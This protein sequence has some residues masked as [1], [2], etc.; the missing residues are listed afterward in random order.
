M[1]Y[2]VWRIHVGW[3]IWLVKPCDLVFLRWFSHDIGGNTCEKLA[4]NSYP[5][6]NQSQVCFQIFDVLGL[7]EWG[8]A[9]FLAI[10]QQLEFEVPVALASPRLPLHMVKISTHIFKH[11]LPQSFCVKCCWAAAMEKF[12]SVQNL[13]FPQLRV[14][15][16]P[17]SKRWTDCTICSHSPKFW[18]QIQRWRLRTAQQ[19][20]TRRRLDFFVAQ[21]AISSRFWSSIK[22]QFL[23][24]LCFPNPAETWWRLRGVLGDTQRRLWRR[25]G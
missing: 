1:K 11:K 7:D 22:M 5:C 9:S 13:L 19:L 8:T 16:L 18:G 25:C 14:F 12:S 24:S 21:D 20:Q 3:G 17:T 2:W 23:L 15:E 4:T 10:Y 6:R